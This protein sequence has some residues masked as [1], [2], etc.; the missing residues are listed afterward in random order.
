MKC[1]INLKN[2]SHFLFEKDVHGKYA[3]QS[4]PI[5]KLW[6]TFKLGFHIEILEPKSYSCPYHFH[7]KEEEL[8]I[9][10]SG[11]ATVRQEN[12]YFQVNEGDLIVFKTGVAHQ[13]YNHT[14]QAFKFFALSNIEPDEICEYPDSNKK[15]ERKDKRL[16]QN[17]IPVEDYW[18]DEEDPDKNW[19]K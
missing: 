4:A 13:F 11:S 12:N 17:S 3:S 14:D 8:F 10:I 2:D 18:K 7:H 19:V 15:W 1:L 5:S 6:N 9:V 16:T